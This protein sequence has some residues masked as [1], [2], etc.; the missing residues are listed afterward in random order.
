VAR[1]IAEPFLTAL[2]D[3]AQACRINAPDIG[4][5]EIGPFIFERQAET[6]QLQI[7][8]AVAA[9]ARVL[10]GGKVETIGGGLYLRPTILTEV[11]PDMDIMAKE[12]FGPVLP[13]TLFDSVEEAVALANRGVFGLSAA[14]IAGTIEEAEAVAERLEAGAVSINDGALTSMVWEA[15]KS[16]FKASGMGPSRMGDS[17]L[18]RFFRRQALIRQAGSPLPLS[19]YS[20]EALT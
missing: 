12:T 17:G 11:T 3:Q 8:Q 19:A 2:I 6:V 16:S 20:E 13:V 10:A 14:V 9:G 1:E 18:L 5:G 4:A 7:D 15:E